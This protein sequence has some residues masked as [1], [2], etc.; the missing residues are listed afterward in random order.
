VGLILLR[1]PDTTESHP[2][3]GAERAAVH[4]M[5]RGSSVAPARIPG[6]LANFVTAVL[7]TDSLDLS[8]RLIA[9]P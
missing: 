7:P 1:R 5:P 6:L 2:I 3:A 8:Y 9:M 4:D